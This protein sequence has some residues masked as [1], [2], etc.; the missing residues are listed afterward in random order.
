MNTAERRGE[1]LKI[2]HNADAPVAARE[3]AGRFGV[4]RQVI[5][6]D[7]AVIRASTP[8]IL[9]TTKGYVIQQ[10]SS[11]TREFK[12]RHS[13]D[14]AAEELNLIVD[15]GGHVKNI[16]IS[17]RV[18][19]R[20]TAEMDIRSR[21][22]V[23]EFA[24]ALRNSRSTVLSSATS[25]YHY[26]L[27]EA[28]SEERLDLI[29]RTTGR[30]GIPCTASAMGTDYRERK[31][32]VMTI[33]EIQQEILRMKKEQDVCILAHAY[34]GQEILEV[35][36]YMGDS[37]GL[38]VQAAR[39]DCSGVIMCGVRFMAETCKVL[40]PDKKVWLANPVAGCPMAE[41]LDLE[42][43][44]KLKAEYPDHAV[45]AYINTTSE[46]K[47]ECDVCVT[48]SSAVQICSKLENDKIL[49]IPESE[50]RTFRCRETSGE[51]ICI[52]QRWMSKTYRSQ[53]QRCRKSET[54]TS[55]RTSSGTSGMP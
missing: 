17:H 25:G 46:L 21:Q 11:F 15:C 36:D 33:K 1:I 26:H 43:L 49:F 47:T 4:S 50:P 3:L 2:L 32:K 20:V 55:G 6:Q 24:E 22:D 52:L 39:S 41:Q 14:K 31:D 51:N 19:G 40:S 44:R 9:S 34:Q 48:S 8:G 5:V 54:G 12:V 42:G 10:D 13:Q 30:G 35:A 7:L 28:S 23:N 38:S 53:R 37:Y 18:Y 16:S 45:V 27:I 29:E